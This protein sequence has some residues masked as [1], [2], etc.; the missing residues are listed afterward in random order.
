LYISVAKVANLE[1]PEEELLAEELPF[2]DYL[3]G[4]T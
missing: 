1:V 2:R 4:R 3:S